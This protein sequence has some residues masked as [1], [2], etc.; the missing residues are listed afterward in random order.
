MVYPKRL[1]PGDTVGII[2]PAGPA[3]LGKVQDALPLF[4]QLGLKVKLG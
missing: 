2:A 3:K 1:K 4:K